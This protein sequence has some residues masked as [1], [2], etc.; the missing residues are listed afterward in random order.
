MS[1]DQTALRVSALDFDAADPKSIERYAKKLIG[2]TLREALG[3]DDSLVAARGKGSF[4]SDLERLYFKLPASNDSAPDFLAAGLELKGSPLK[5]LGRDGRL[6]PKER[7]SLSMIDYECIVREDWETS[8]FLKKNRHILFVFYLYEPDISSTLDYV[9]KLVGNWRIPEE[10]LLFLRADWK[11]I[12]GIIAEEGPDALSG[13]R[14]QNLEAAK[15]GAKGATAKR[16]FAFKPSFVKKYILPRV[17]WSQPLLPQDLDDD[18][19]VSEEGRIAALF[20]PYLESTAEELAQRLGVRSTVRAKSFHADV[21]KAILDIDPDNAIEDV[22]IKTIRLDYDKTIP[23][24]SVSFP[25]FDYLDLIQQQWE[26]SDLRE[27]LSKPFLFVVYREE[28]PGG[29]RILVGAR[30]WKMPKVDLE[31]EVHRVWEETVGRIES[32]RADNLP[33]MSESP[34]CHVRPHGRDS[35]DR[36]PTP[37]NGMQVKKCFWLRASYIGA[38][39]WD[40]VGP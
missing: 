25:H 32:G 12:R 2:S 13:S 20:A 1:D 21:T 35:R 36:L 11:T 27:V 23:R 18:S 34:I 4:G 10:C 37:A 15:K 6:V 5:R 28:S 22:T 16:A 7:I 24:E 3:A 17:T 9:I 39:I 26:S 38:A 40:V 8:A 30:L 29:R 33:K 14:T 31:G 19:I